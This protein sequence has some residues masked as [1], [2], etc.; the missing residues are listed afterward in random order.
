MDVVNREDPSPQNESKT[1]DD[2]GEVVLDLKDMDFTEYVDAELQDFVRLAHLGLSEEALHWFDTC[3]AKH[4]DMFPVFAEYVDM[5]LQ[6]GLLQQGP[7]EK[8]QELLGNLL[9]ELSKII[10][11]TRTLRQL[12]GTNA[13]DRKQLFSVMEM[14]VKLRLGKDRQGDLL[15]AVR[16]CR[17]YIKKEWA[18]EP[19]PIQVHIIELYLDLVVE[20]ITRKLIAKADEDEYTNPPWTTEGSTRWLGFGVWYKEL[21]KSE[22][23]WQA[24][25]IFGLLIAQMG[26]ETVL[27]TLIQ[28]VPSTYVAE[29]SQNE[30]FDEA[31]GLSELVISNTTCK[32]LMSV[33]RPQ[34]RLIRLTREYLGASHSLKTML[35]LHSTLQDID[36]GMPLQEVDRLEELFSRW[37]GGVPVQPLVILCDGTWCG[38]E[39]DT[40]SNIYLLA[41][42]VGIDIDDPTDTDEHFLKDKAW[43]IHGVGLGSTF[44]K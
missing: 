5:L 26:Y 25:R 21:R 28:K 11:E 34:A 40:R 36:R 43:Y 18:K 29:I 6:Q 35:S 12:D 1:N 38:R 19:S 24:Q 14:V 37:I 30:G 23:H 8:V 15:A 13:G 16:D 44:I 4:Q 20:A 9:G 7:R 32:Y 10:Q 3:L 42:V 31:R 2:Y 17:Q 27:E 33:D 39:M 22:Y 41:R